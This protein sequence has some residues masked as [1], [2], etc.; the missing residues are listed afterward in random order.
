MVPQLQS[1]KR[2]E[3]L[4]SPEKENSF[5]GL[6]FGS[7]QRKCAEIS[8]SLSQPSLGDRVRAEAARSGDVPLPSTST[9]LT[10]SP[11]FVLAERSPLQDCTLSPEAPKQRHSPQRAQRAPAPPTPAP[12]VSGALGVPRAPRWCLPEFEDLRRK[13]QTSISALQRSNAQQAEMQALRRGESFKEEAQEA[14]R[15]KDRHHHKWCAAQAA[16]RAA[17]G[18]ERSALEEA[19]A[20]GL[21]ALARELLGCRGT[22]KLRGVLLRRGTQ[23]YL[24]ADVSA[25][26]SFEDRQP[27]L[28]NTLQQLSQSTE[29]P[30]LQ[31]GLLSDMS[32]MYAWIA[33]AI[34][35]SRLTVAWKDARDGPEVHERAADERVAQL[36]KK[37]A[38]K[39]LAVAS[40]EHEKRSLRSEVRALQNLVQ[41]L[42]GS[43]RVFCRIRPPREPTAGGA[44]TEAQ[45]SR[46]I[47]LR[48]PAGDK[49]HD[50]SFDR[51]FSQEASQRDLYEEVE[52]LIPGVL[53]GIHVCIF[54][55]GQTGAGKTY[56]LAGNKRMGEPG[57]Q[58]LAIADLL[59]LAAVDGARFDVRLSAL[60]IY[61]ESIQDLLSELR[62]DPNG[63]QET[64]ERLEVR[65]SREDLSAS[66]PSPFGSMRVPGLKSWP[67]R[68]PPDVEQALQ[69]IASQRHVASTALNERSSRSHCVL[70]LSV[71]PAGGSISEEGRREATG[72]LHIVDLAGSERTKISQAE[73]M[74]MKEA[75]CIN[76]SLSALSDVLYALGDSTG[77]AHIPFRNSKLT[78]L[79]QD[80]LGGPGCK[81]FLLAQVS[82][83]S[84]DVNESY[85]TLTFAS[86]VAANVQKGR[87]R[88]LSRGERGSPASRSCDASPRL[89]SQDSEPSLP[90]PVLRARG[91]APPL[92]GLG[93][94]PSSC[95]I[96]NE[97][98]IRS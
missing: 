2:L 70:S 55:Y 37:L 29:R 68:E 33:R 65:Q 27:K 48:K 28:H 38:Q 43:I 30:S 83:D 9:V 90:S 21:A 66:W 42:R 45:G 49:R 89:R 74:Q 96:T 91:V 3:A 97:L 16:E 32:E 26:Q 56:T 4:R 15:S 10:W 69:R 20:R 31:P 41:E 14:K 5:P 18:A 94:K 53:Q 92:P 23:S 75:N 84:A 98:R 24:D 64:S 52:P 44:G 11:S 95:S 39:E 67:V 47:S 36:E 35:D 54:A 51:V 86:R 79:L 61:N 19:A 8:A 57:I 46:S 78:Y 82:P 81:T 1:P 25:S 6:E 63:P 59:K 76:R 13:M 72:V 85:S 88:P 62:G 40:L 80:A 60:E 58:D 71:R 87:L 17:R 93:R 34:S 7:F 73:G 12:L 22:E 77:N 50:F